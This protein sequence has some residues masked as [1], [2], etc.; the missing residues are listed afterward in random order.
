[1]TATPPEPTVAGVET[2]PH[3]PEELF[4]THFASLCRT[5]YLMVGDAGVAEELVME[6]FSRTLPRWSAVQSAD[7]PVAYVRRAVINLCASRVRRL[8][9]ERRARNRN[10]GPQPDRWDADLADDSRLVLDAVRHLPDRQRACVVL[11]YFEDL[12]EQSI[13]D[14]LGC[15]VGTVKSQ[16][17]KA[18]SRLAEL[19]DPRH[20]EG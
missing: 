8:A 14:L 2:R 9:V 11:R 19:L 6:A 15:T 1:M 12:S 13:A 3:A 4:R 7:Q 20:Q 17:A 16:L 10:D 18:R 5:A